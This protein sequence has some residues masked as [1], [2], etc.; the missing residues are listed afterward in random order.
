MLHLPLESA[1]QGE[2]EGAQIVSQKRS[3]VLGSAGV[4]RER[5]ELSV[6]IE[7][8]PVFEFLMARRDQIRAGYFGANDWR[9][10]LYR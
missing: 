10:F 3:A 1:P 5:K 2:S 4:D 9:E 8:A 6:L 7:P